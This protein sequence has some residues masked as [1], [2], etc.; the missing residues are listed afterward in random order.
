MIDGRNDD[1]FRLEITINDQKT[2]DFTGTCNIFI[3]S[4]IFVHIE[5]WEIFY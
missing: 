3:V 4:R 5:C 2:H 1:N